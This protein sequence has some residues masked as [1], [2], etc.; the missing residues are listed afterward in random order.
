M[1]VK[2]FGAQ[3]LNMRMDAMQDASRDLMGRLALRVIDEEKRLAP[4]KTGNL[5]R[6]IQ[7][8]RVTAREANIK[9]GAN[10]SAYVEYGTRA[11]VIEPRNKSVLRWKDGGKVRFARR[12][13]HPGTKAQPFMIPGFEAAIK[14]SGDLLDAI[15]KAWNGAA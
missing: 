9:A 15:V 14:R 3:Q 10:Y 13:R 5:R 12:V 6:S 7:L 1:N 4:V 8:G 11:H 2:L